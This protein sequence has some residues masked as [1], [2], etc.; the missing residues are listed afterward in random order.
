M[1]AG[2]PRSWK[3]LVNR[4]AT[5]IGTD[6]AA[7]ALSDFVK[8]VE[9]GPKLAI[10]H[11]HRGVALMYLGKVAD[12]VAAYTAAIEREP[13]HA[14]ADQF[15]GMLRMS[16]G[17]LDAALADFDSA[18]SCRTARRATFSAAMPILRRASSPR[19]SRT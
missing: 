5:Q 18:S 1:I 15:R 13:S 4:G 14:D 19:R 2:N 6:D 16:A 9:I 17:Q 7:A 11:F 12:A 10:T 3:A 8:A